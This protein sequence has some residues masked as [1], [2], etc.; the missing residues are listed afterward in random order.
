MVGDNHDNKAT[1]FL[2]CSIE[3]KV[4]NINVHIDKF[5]KHNKKPCLGFG[6]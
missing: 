4:H 2:I 6:D 5:G 1:D 3:T